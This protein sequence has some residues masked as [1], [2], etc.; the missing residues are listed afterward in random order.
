MFAPPNGD[1]RITLASTLVS[2]PLHEQFLNSITFQM[3]KTGA[4]LYHY[5]KMRNFQC[6]LHHDIYHCITEFINSIQCKRL[7]GIGECRVTNSS[8]TTLVFLPFF[9][10]SE[11]ILFML[12]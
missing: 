1:Y 4:H 3:E 2:L 7:T 5:L 8:N 11:A 12:P 6:L 9:L 10:N